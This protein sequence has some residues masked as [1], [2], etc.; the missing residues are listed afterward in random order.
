MIELVD[1]LCQLSDWPPRGRDRCLPSRDGAAPLPDDAHDA[2]PGSREGESA[3]DTPN[4]HLI[5]WQ[6][7]QPP[8]HR[9]CAGR[10]CWQE[11]ICW[12]TSRGP[13]VTRWPWAG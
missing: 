11:R 6:S 3:R 10:S 4:R 1:E 5:I 9:G 12:G 13:P 7:V 2:T 8:A